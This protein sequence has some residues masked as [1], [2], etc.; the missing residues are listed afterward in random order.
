MQGYHDH[1]NIVGNTLK[2]EDIDH[3]INNLTEGKTEAL[4]APEETGDTGESGSVRDQHTV[5]PPVSHTG[6]I[7]TT[8][9]LE[10]GTVQPFYRRTGKGGDSEGAQPGDWVPFDGLAKGGIHPDSTD[11]QVKVTNKG[12]FDKGAYVKEG[13]ELHRW[14]TEENKKVGQ[15]LRRAFE[16]GNLFEDQSKIDIEKGVVE[17]NDFQNDEEGHK[18]VNE[19]LESHNSDQARYKMENWDN[20]EAKQLPNFANGI[21]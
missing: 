11:T 16:E 4:P 14:G 9:T 3:H 5:T 7:I 17:G 12:W 6:H 1:E 15:D 8:V 21:I 19:H 2:G 10:D 20:E 13:G 18:G